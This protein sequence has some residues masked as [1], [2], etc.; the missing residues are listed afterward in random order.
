MY[1]FKTIIKD[2]LESIDFLISQYEDK[3]H[4][5]INGTLCYRK[6]NKQIVYFFQNECMLDGK[7][8]RITHRLGDM[9]SDDVVAIKTMRFNHETL[10][11]LKVDKQLLGKIIERY[12][13]Y[14][15]EAVH[16]DLPSAYMDLPKECFVDERYEELKEWACEEYAKNG[17]ELP[18]LANITVTGEKVR[19]KG[20]VIIYNMLVYYGIP[21]RY[22][23]RLEL[24]DANGF[25]VTRYPDFAI[26]TKSGRVIYW[27][28]LGPL[29]KEDYYNNFIEK[30]MLYHINGICAGD[31]L[32]LT[33]NRI[34]GSINT[35][36]IED[37]IKYCIL[38]LA[39]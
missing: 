33:A 35:K 29:E 27:E 12:Q 39:K 5:Q 1:N 23:S 9:Y 14:S 13:D 24:I 17:K 18:K 31:N 10:K 19:S 34:G 4:R 6:R 2:Q 26:Q 15:P 8:T 25:K 32:I 20:E 37:I 30:I 22:D 36:A 16:R 3:P 28:H 7:K 38:P 21:F 11:R